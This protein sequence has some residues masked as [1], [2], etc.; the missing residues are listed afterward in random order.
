MKLTIDNRLI[1]VKR[2]TRLDELIARFNTISQ[3]KFYVE[4]LGSSFLD[5]EN[6][7]KKYYESLNQVK[8]DLSEIAR[9][10]IIDRSFLPNFVFDDTDMII[11]VG[12]DGLVANTLKYLNGQLIFGINP[13]R[14]RWDGVLL[15]FGPEETASA[16]IE[17]V[18][19]KRSI[20]DVSMAKVRMQ[21][22]QELLAVND[23][24]IGQKT[25][26]SARYI[27]KHRKSEEYQSSSGIIVS[28]GL[29]SSGWMRSIIA[30]ACGI[31]DS[32][33]KNK[34][35]PK[36]SENSWNDTF[37]TFSV[38]EPFPSRT[39]GVSLVFGRIQ[40]NEHLTVVSQ[41]GENGVIFSDGIEKDYIEFNSG[42]EAKISV[43]ERKGRIV[44]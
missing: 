18:K 38:R 40:S 36:K 29:G 15:P 21:N 14:D 37:L 9:I 6:E 4:H 33:S 41:M 10:Q 11:A 32:V 20:Q 35:V 13:D 34:T 8:K 25:H 19:G 3:A 28:T 22:G 42:M 17:T 7:H 5:Y 39:T 44:V 2:K 27:I 12:Q 23:F 43:S 1:I 31:A 16:V 24:F 26:T 30:G